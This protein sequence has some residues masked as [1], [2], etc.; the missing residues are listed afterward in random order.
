MKSAI[1][2]QAEQI[3]CSTFET[4]GSVTKYIHAYRTRRGR[5]LALERAR[6][7]FYVW[8]ELVGGIPVGLPAPEQYEAARSR[9][10]NLASN[11]KRLGTGR[12][13]L[14]WRLDS[15]EQLQ[16]LCD[17]YAAV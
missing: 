7:G 6:S 15:A 4:T 9:N 12:A 16:E 1:A 14:Y 11:A 13:A 17:W 8:T 10:S 3:L 5:E 2:Q